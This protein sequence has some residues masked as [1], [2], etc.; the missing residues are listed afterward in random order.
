MRAGGSGERRLTR[1]GGVAIFPDFSPNGR[2]LG[3]LTAL[4]N[5]RTHPTCAIVRRV[6]GLS[7]AVRVKIDVSLPTKVGTGIDIF[8]TQSFVGP[9]IR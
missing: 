9:L 8:L 2:R 5:G 7:Y 3:Q 6:T 1:L 4:V